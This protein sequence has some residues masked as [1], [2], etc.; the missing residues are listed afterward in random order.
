V[1]DSEHDKDAMERLVNKFPVKPGDVYFIPAKAI[2]AIGKGCLILEIQEPTDFTIQPERLC[3]DYRLSD[4]QMYLDLDKK[5]ALSVF[6]YSYNK[7]RVLNE[8]RKT[9]TVISEAN[10]CVKTS[11]ISKEDTPCFSL[12]RY[13]I[14]NGRTEK[15]SAPVIYVVTE[16]NGVLTDG[17]DHTEIKKGDYFFMPYSCNKKYFVESDS[18]LTLAACIPPEKE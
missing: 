8:C 16:G 9:P 2:H 4:K 11:I 13:E 15:L 18:N 6:D 10:G 7:E 17:T 3:G 14:N 5:T 1:N 12:E